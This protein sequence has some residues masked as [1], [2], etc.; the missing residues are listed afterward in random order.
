[1]NSPHIRKLVHQSNKIRKVS[2][3]LNIDNA[4]IGGQNQNVI[5]NITRR[6]LTI[7]FAKLN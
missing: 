7:S 3:K 1:M 5:F 4:L 6:M 2:F